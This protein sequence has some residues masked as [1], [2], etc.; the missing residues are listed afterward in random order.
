[1]IAV[2]LGASCKASTLS[3]SEQ[4]NTPYL[5]EN[6]SGFQ[7]RILVDGEVTFAEAESAYLGLIA[8]LNQAGFEASG[9]ETDEQGGFAFITRDPPT[10]QAL[11][12]NKTMTRC[13]L[14]Y[15]SAVEVAWADATATSPEE[16]AAF[17]T[18]VAS[19]LR[20]AGLAVAD[21]SPEELARVF[22]ADPISYDKCLDEVVAA[23][24]G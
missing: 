20:R 8:C 14:E 16:E 23:T 11:A 12:F 5:S 4:N 17:Y 13:E 24:G 10:S 6:L 7:A 9:L 19:C 3:P 18:E 22:E 1:M 15:T 2:S 21:A